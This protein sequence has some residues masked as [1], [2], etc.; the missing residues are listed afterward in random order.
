MSWDVPD[1]DGGGEITCYSIEKLRSFHK[2][3]G[4]WC[5]SVARTTFKVPNLVKDAEYQFRVR[6][7]N[8]YESANHLSQTSFWP[9]TSSGFLAPRKASYIQ[10][11]L[12][13]CH[14]LGMLQFTMVVQRVTGYHVE[15]KERNSI[16][17]QRIMSPISGREYR[18]TGLMEGLIT[19][20]VYSLKICWSSSPS[21]PSKFTLVISSR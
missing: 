18:A 10:C 15:K 4:R 6:A 14:S 2:L 3:I 12:M 8:R 5:S 9:N 13:A 16:L 7:E 21:D 1:D 19:S 20:S 11:D 17:W